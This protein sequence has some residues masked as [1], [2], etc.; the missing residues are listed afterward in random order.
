MRTIVSDN[1]R[2]GKHRS[3]N[4]YKRFIMSRNIIQM[5]EFIHLFLSHSFKRIG[6]VA[7]VNVAVSACIVF[8]V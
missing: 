7:Y 5:H 6:E 2:R 3:G 8:T 4:V 1:R